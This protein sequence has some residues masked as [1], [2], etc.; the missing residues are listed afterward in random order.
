MIDQ[1]SLMYIQDGLLI[2]DGDDPKG[3]QLAEDF[4]R[5]RTAVLAFGRMNPPTRGHQ[6]IIDKINDTARMYGGTPML[7]LSH[8]NDSKKNPLSYDIKLQWCEKAF[9]DK[10]QVVESTAKNM[11]EALQELYSDGYTDIVYVCGSD[12]FGEAENLYKYNG[13]PNKSGQII[14]DFNSIKIVMAGNERVESF[15]DI[16]VEK[17]SASMQREFAATDQLQ[18]FMYG[19]PE[20]LSANERKELYRDVRAGLG[21]SADI[22]TEGLVPTN[23]YKFLS[24]TLQSAMP[25]TF[26]YGD[27]SRHKKFGELFRVKTSTTV[28][29]DTILNEIKDQINNNEMLA[30]VGI[31][32]YSMHADSSHTFKSLLLTYNGNNYYVVIANKAK[33]EFTPNKILKNVM[34]VNIDY[35]NLGQLIENLQEIR[36][37]DI[38][39]QSISDVRST[40]I[41]KFINDLKSGQSSNISTQFESSFDGSILDE[42]SQAS[43]PS[44]Q[45]DFGEILGAGCLASA[46]SSALGESIS[47][48]FPRASNEPLVD[49]TLISKDTQ[50]KVSEKAGAGAAPSCESLFQM[51]SEDAKGNS[52]YDQFINWMYNNL[53]TV[54]V[55]QGFVNMAN[56]ALENNESWYRNINNQYDISSIALGPG[57]VTAD[58]IG[59]FT[60]NCRR[61]YNTSLKYDPR[62]VGD[63]GYCETIR[64][65]YLARC[66]W[67]TINNSPLIDEFNNRLRLKLGTFIQVYL[68]SSPAEFLNGIL[69]FQAVALS[70]SGKKY[71]FV[72]GSQLNAD[73]VLYMKRLSVVIK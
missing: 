51:L 48:V 16:P 63:P 64:I 55:H 45:N 69:K 41:N 30:D 1:D 8:S 61:L 35:L 13:I 57:E 46:I 19:C 58:N 44:I 65:R 31:G 37:S 11:Y 28:S 17:V 47:V 15:D 9:D 21:L 70:E 29:E 33:K 23:D 5:K 36:F 62:R 38:Y 18:Q 2:Y 25:P 20:R 72:D 7:F 14:F 50:F 67:M 43:I 26:T 68:K 52:D 39:D 12:R 22:I 6:L 71:Y 32:D 60:T 10:V 27:S 56:L 40:G 49:Y 59:E 24:S 34:G 53:A 4:G 54:S 66:V 73:N 42:V 3:D